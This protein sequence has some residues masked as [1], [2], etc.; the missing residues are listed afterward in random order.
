MPL[1]PVIGTYGGPGHA[2]ADLGRRARTGRAGD[3]RL[4]LA[5]LRAI[6]AF[7]VARR[8]LVITLQ[9]VFLAALAVF[10]TIELRSTWHGAYPRLRHAKLPYLLAAGGAIAAYYLVVRVRLAGDPPAVRRARC[11]TCPRCGPRC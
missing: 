9:L 2:R 5:R 1:G 8:W 3:A 11:R 6:F 7:V 10:L 4:M